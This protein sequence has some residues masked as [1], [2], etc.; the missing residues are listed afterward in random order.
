[1]LIRVPQT[2]PAPVVAALAMLVLAG[3]DLSGSLA[4]KEA[5]LR[6]SPALAVVGA[7][8]FVAL[9]WVYASSLQYADLA[10]VTLGWIVVLQVGVVLLD[11]FRYD[12]RIATGTWVAIAVIVTAQ[13]YL[14]FAV[15]G[16]QAEPAGDRAERV[17][18]L[19][20]AGS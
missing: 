16:G 11:R 2:W 5:V 3:L 15:G 10:P 17:A 13:A 12:T 14:L 9:F 1:M 19:P 6:R 20:Q 7:G 18:V 8:L 4:A